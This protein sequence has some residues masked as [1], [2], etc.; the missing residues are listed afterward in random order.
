MADNNIP[1]CFARHLF[2]GGALFQNRQFG[3][4]FRSLSGIDFK[5]F[6]IFAKKVS[7]HFISCVNILC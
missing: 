7:L 2:N 4:L 3:D 6:T 1:M 5:S